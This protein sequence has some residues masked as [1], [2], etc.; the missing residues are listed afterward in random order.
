MLFL[1][2]LSCLDLSVSA[3]LLPSAVAQGSEYVYTHTSTALFD[4]PTPSLSESQDA[5][6]VNPPSQA[7]AHTHSVLLDTGRV[8]EGGWFGEDM[9]L[10][11]RWGLYV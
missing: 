1:T 9:S 4:A 10:A 11:D 7:H 8:C 2:N 3:P 5:G 6:P